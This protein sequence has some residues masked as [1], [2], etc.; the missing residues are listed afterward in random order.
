MEPLVYL[1]T[2]LLCVTPPI[3]TH[4]KRS[5]PTHILSYHFT[6]LAHNHLVF[7]EMDWPGKG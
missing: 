7:P 6:V 2:R 5:Y 4:K 3:H 1:P